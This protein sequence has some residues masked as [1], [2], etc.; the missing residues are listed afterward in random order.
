M[1]LSGSLR[2][3]TGELPNCRPRFVIEELVHLCKLHGGKPPLLSE[4]WQDM[5]NSDSINRLYC[6]TCLM[7]KGICPGHSLLGM[8]L[9][10]TIRRVILDTVVEF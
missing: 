2:H 3:V 6:I 5:G 1:V 10:V 4:I 7:Q 8:N 9:Y